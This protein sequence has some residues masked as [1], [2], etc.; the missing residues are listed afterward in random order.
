[1]TTASNSGLTTREEWR[2]REVTEILERALAED[3]G[4]GDLTTD[5]TVPAPVEAAGTFLA[6]EVMVVAGL[7][8]VERLFELLN[9]KMRFRALVEEGQLVSRG[10]LAEVRGDARALLRGERTALNFLQRLSAPAARA[11]QHR[12]HLQVLEHR[13]AGE[14]LAPLGDLADAEVAD[15]VR[16]QPE[17]G[18]LLEGNRPGSWLLYSRNAAD[19]RGL[20]GAVGADDGDD[21][22]L[23]HAERDA[24]ERLRVAVVQIE[25][26]HF[27]H[28]TS[29]SSPR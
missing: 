6:Q 26:F 18:F 22:A 24:I 27:Q 29:V 9:P 7:P 4:S 21:L 20:A 16:F 10:V 15:G 5:A 19:E 12:A 11:R 3:L 1:M 13:E 8:V 25:I 14:H 2:V 23:G 28:Q 17:N